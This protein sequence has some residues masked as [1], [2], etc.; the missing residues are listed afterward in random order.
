MPML[1]SAAFNLNAAFSPTKINAAA[2][3][4]GAFAPGMPL[5]ADFVY[6]AGSDEHADLTA[7]LGFMPMAVKESIRATIYFALT[8]N[9]PAPVTFTWQPGYYFSVAVSQLPATKIRQGAINL[10]IEGPLPHDR[11]SVMHLYDVLPVSAAALP[12]KS[13]IRG[14]PRPDKR[15][16]SKRSRKSS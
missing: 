4:A 16:P 5:S 11:F 14:S 1:E 15:K 10:R 6:P 13:S 9:P 7:Y 2:S 12:R 3:D 8:R